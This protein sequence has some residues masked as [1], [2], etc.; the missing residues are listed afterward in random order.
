MAD[1]PGK[2]ERKVHPGTGEIPPQFD[3]SGREL[4]MCNNCGLAEVG[5]NGVLCVQCI[6]QEDLRGW[7]STDLTG[8]EEEVSKDLDP[9][10][11]R[12]FI[13]EITT[14]RESADFIVEQERRASYPRL[15]DTE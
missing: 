14:R 6:N 13:P 2:V 11:A 3:V 15:K 5:A 1:G 7:Y 12:M 4:I 10:I 8:R 9:A